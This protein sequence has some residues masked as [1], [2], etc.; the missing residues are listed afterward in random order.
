[1]K[2]IFVPSVSGSD[3]QRLLGK[4]ELH[5]KSGHS[6]MSA[7]ACW[8]DSEPR[9]P[10]EIS[11]ALE[12]TGEKTFASLE[13]LMAVPEWEVELPGG[14]IRLAFQ[15]PQARLERPRQSGGRLPDYPACAL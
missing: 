4:P 13:L 11:S 2:R 1:M 6:A 9:L 3:W 7:A 5:W 14:D 12:A 10:P 8:E 15:D